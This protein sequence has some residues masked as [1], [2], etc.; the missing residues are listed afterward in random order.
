MDPASE[1]ISDGERPPVFVSNDAAPGRI[2]LLC[3]HASNRFPASLNSLGLND[4]TVSSHAAWDPGA[5]GVALHLSSALDAPLIASNYSRLVCDVNRPPDSPDAFRD[6]SEIYRVPGNEKLPV[7]ER[8]TRTAAIYEP[9]HEAVS[10]CLDT[11]SAG[12]GT[13]LLVTI[14]SF[15]PV[16]FGAIRDTELGILHGR[17]SR[18][19]DILIE[20]A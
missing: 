11:R 7:E 18:L 6:N 13:T 17:D 1:L 8:R 20:L 19:G 9:F 14:H 15:T 5:L 12:N 10:N 3:E 2:L 16:Y 4:E